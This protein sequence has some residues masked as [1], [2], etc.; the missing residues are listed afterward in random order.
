VADSFVMAATAVL[1]TALLVGWYRR[2]ARPMG[3]LRVGLN[4]FLLPS[5]V[6]VFL[7]P[8]PPL[9]MNAIIAIGVTGVLILFCGIGCAARLVWEARQDLN[10]EST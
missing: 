3:Y 4:L 6:A 1:V 5:T 9:L 2:P 8:M 7:R 10:D